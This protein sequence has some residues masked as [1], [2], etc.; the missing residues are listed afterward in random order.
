M[1]VGVGDRGRQAGRRVRH[2]G[3]RSAR[4]GARRRERH[5]HVP[6]HRAGPGRVQP[7][8]DRAG[9]VAAL[10]V[11]ARDPD[12]PRVPRARG[13]AAGERAHHPVRHAVR[14]AE[15]RRRGRVRA[16]E[17]AARHHRRGQ[18]R[19]DAL[20]DD[21]GRH[22]GSP[23]ADR[24]GLPPGPDRGR[25]RGDHPGP[26]HHRA[27]PPAGRRLRAGR[28]AGPVVRR[29]ERAA[30]RGVGRECEPRAGRDDRR[31]A[32]RAGRPHAGRRRAGVRRAAADV[33][34]AGRPDQPARPPAPRPRR[35]AGT[36]GGAGVAALDRDGRGAVRR[37]PHR[38]R[39]PAAGPGPPA[40]PAPADDRRH[41]P[42]GAAVEGRGADRPHRPAGRPRRARGV[43][44]HPAGGLVQPGAPGVRDLHVRVH[45]QAQGRRHAV[46]RPDEHAPQPP[47]RDLRPGHRG[48]GRTAA[49][50]R[51]HRVVR[52]RHVVGR[53]AVAGGGPRGARV[54]RGAAPRR[55]GAGGLLRRAPG[56]RGQRD[57]DLRAPADRGGPARRARPG[58]G[59][60]R[61]RGRV[62]RGVEPAARHPRHVR[63]QPVRADR[64]HDQHP[65][66]VH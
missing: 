27:R 46:P 25:A 47:G 24:A 57:A 9:A 20:P 38:R 62:R 31:P 30:G 53:A 59:A 8:R 34:G 23:R 50:D 61:R 39:L 54:R 16:A 11:R 40:G 64:V 51:A 7:A 6:Q 32:G 10:A 45:R 3:R 22:A 29:R 41:R 48:G 37:A 1:G 52:V 5:R 65:R 17:G 42:G 35:G 33:R 56:R 28:H 60:A 44:D 63:L 58:A 14:V 15:L 13:R 4:R 49:A 43:P 26:V 18:R 21:A 12:E 2:H 55:P 19:L 36:R 66:R